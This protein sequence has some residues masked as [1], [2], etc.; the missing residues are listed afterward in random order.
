MGVR[1]LISVAVYNMVFISI[2]LHNMNRITCSVLRGLCSIS[3]CKIKCQKEAIQINAECLV[4]CMSIVLSVF[5]LLFFFY[6][7]LFNV[8][9]SGF[10]Q[11]HENKPV[12]KLTS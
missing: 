9:G 3:H 7:C 12:P 10:A 5:E 2:A 8:M 11:N 1:V 4:I 6:L